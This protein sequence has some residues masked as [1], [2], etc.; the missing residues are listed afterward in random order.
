[1]SID[2]RI[3]S[4]GGEQ[5]VVCSTALPRGDFISAEIQSRVTS[6]DSCRRVQ[7]S[8]AS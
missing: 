7:Q 2:F 1:M 3:A 4:R 6:A 5:S 8:E